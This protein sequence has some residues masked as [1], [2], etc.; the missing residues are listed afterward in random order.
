M[1]ASDVVRNAT[2]MMGMRKRRREKAT[3]GFTEIPLC[4]N[5]KENKETTGTE[6]GRR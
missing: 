3:E 4:S 6:K 5:G 2:L 1:T